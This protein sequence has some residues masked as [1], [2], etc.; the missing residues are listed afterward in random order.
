MAKGK[1]FPMMEMYS[2]AKGLIGHFRRLYAWNAVPETQAGRS[3][4]CRREL[5][6]P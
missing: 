4:S 2:H 6:D 5:Q 3:R 1:L